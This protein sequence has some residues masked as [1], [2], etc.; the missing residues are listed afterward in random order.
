MSGF[1]SILVVV[2]VAR[3]M[4]FVAEAAPTDV[5]PELVR[6]ATLWFRATLVGIAILA[7]VAVAVVAVSRFR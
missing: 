3:L 4:L 7:L 5:R 1:W 2:M 6:K